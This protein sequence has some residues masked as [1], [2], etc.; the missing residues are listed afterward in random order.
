MDAKGNLFGCL[1]SSKA[2]YMADEDSEELL[3][4]KL[5]YA[6]KQKQSLKFTGSSLSMLEIGG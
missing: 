4:Q 6:M 3:K 2:V 5:Q 1:S